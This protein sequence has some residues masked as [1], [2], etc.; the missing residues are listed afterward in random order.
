MARLVRLTATGPVKIE[1]GSIP[2]D[3]PLWIC[4]CGLSQ[5][6]PFCDGSHKITRS[7]QP[8]MI[9]IYTRDGKAVAEVRPEPSDSSTDAAPASPPTS[10]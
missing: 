10:G 4:A 2:A 1:P 9:Y 6:L 7:E 8:G 5:R 3:K